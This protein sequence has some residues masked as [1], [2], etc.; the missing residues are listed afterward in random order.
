MSLFLSRKIGG[1]IDKDPSTKQE[2]AL[3]VSVFHT[4]LANTFT[5]LDV[6]L[7]QLATAALFFGMRS[8]EYLD[9][10]GPRKMIKLTISEV[11]TTRSNRHT[12]HL[13]ELF[14]FMFS[15][16]FINHNI[17][18]EIFLNPDLFYKTV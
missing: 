4:L 8:C 7:G 10:K 18:T 2:K 13:Q 14:L 16:F 15:I 11:I 9:V 6:A 5:P 17:K 1:Y 3:P 12:Q